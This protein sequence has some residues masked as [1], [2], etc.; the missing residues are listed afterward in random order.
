MPQNLKKSLK[1][2]YEAEVEAREVALKEQISADPSAKDR[3]TQEFK[4]WK[5]E[6]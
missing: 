2:E 5:K 4:A 1:N 3:L 6:H